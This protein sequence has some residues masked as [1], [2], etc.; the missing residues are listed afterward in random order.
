MPQVAA[1]PPVKPSPANYHLAG[2]RDRASGQQERET[3]SQTNFSGEN[4]H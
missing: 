1:F 3:S 2:G 4:T